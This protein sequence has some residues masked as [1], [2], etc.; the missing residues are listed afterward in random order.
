MIDT[1]ENP[2][3]V[4]G[5]NQPPTAFDGFSA[6]IE[7]L[8]DEAGNW[9]NGDGV[10]NEAEAEGVSRL[11]NMLRKARKDADAARVEEKRPH[12][13]AAKAVQSKWKPLL[14]KCELAETTAKR[15]LTPYLERKE[16]E[17]RA[18]AERLR[19][20]AEEAAR[21]AREAHQAASTDLAAAGVA[22]AAEE[23]AAELTKLANRAD[24]TK[25]HATGGERAIGLRSH[26]VATV[27]DYT[28]FARW[29][30]AERPD[31]MHKFLD[32]LAGK[33]VGAGKR[34]LPGVDITEQRKAA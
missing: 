30:W 5:S 29:A 20:E 13:E 4:I 10:N 22:K 28:A 17:Q 14:D 26:W 8:F 3:A 18:E 16:A 12:D 27:E 23:A 21:K 9:L 15:A 1:V 24:K 7:D 6:H 25:A 2:R 34:T 11:L 32:E 33:E 31:D 19:Q